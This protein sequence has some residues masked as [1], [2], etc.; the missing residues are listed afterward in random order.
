MCL[1]ALERRGFAGSERIHGRRPTRLN[2]HN[3]W[4]PPRLRGPL[5]T[6]WCVLPSKNCT[7]RDA[8]ALQLPAT[9]LEATGELLGPYIASGQI[10]PVDPACFLRS[11]ISLSVDYYIPRAEVLPYYGWDNEAEIARIVVLMLDGL[12]PRQKKRAARFPE[13][14][15][16]SHAP[17]TS[18]QRDFVEI[19]PLNNVGE[20]VDPLVEAGQI[21]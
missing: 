13:Q 3:T 5:Y 10:R 15:L 6:L 14:P 12:R 7:L 19:K 8:I 16:L 20:P 9:V 11:V 21:G 18:V 1:G 17:K 2:V 4:Q